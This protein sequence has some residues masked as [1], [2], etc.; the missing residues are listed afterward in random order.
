MAIRRTRASPEDFPCRAAAFRRVG[1]LLL[2]IMMLLTVVALTA[3][4]AAPA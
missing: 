4:L 3:T 1:P 2:N